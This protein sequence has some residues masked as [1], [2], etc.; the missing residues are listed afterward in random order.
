METFG[1]VVRRLRAQ[2]GET[3]AQVVNNLNEGKGSAPT[4]VSI[5]MLSRIETDDRYP[6]TRTA[7]AIA[8]Y[9]GVPASEAVALLT[10]SQARRKWSTLSPLERGSQPLPA[11]APDLALSAAQALGFS[12]E[13]MDS[14]ARLREALR[15]EA[16]SYAP[17]M[18]EP[19]VSAVPSAFPA[20]HDV[21]TVSEQDRR[22]GA[23]PVAESMAD[24]SVAMLEIAS[25][26]LDRAL[27]DKSLRPDTRERIA[28]RAIDLAEYII[29][30]AKRR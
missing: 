9:Y 19:T 22:T 30:V 7:V 3:L 17:V 18:A 8:E 23:G 11:A 24:E 6:S 20:S 25:R 10:E 2:R 16:D 21:D 14:R 12:D 1:Q 15:I 26:Q 13:A 28:Q 29:L 4:K 27:A 5:P